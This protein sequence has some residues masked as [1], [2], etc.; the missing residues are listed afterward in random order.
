MR[1][2]Y[3][4]RENYSEY[5]WRGLGQ[6]FYE[7]GFGW[8]ARLKSQNIYQKDWDVL[9]LLDCTRRDMIQ[10]IKDEY[11]FINNIGEHLTPGTSSANW[12]LYTFTKEYENQMSET[13][14]VTG[15]PNSEKYLNSSDFHHLEE[16]WRNNWSEEHGTIL[17]RP[18]TNQAVRLYRN[19]NPNKMIVHYMQ[20]HPPFVPNKSVDSVEISVPN[21]SPSGKTVE[22]LAQSGYSRSE[23]WELHVNNLRYVLEDVEL[24]LSNIDAERA[25]ISADHGQALGERGK[26]GHPGA[27]TLDCLRKVPWVKTSASDSG[28]HKPV[29]QRNQ[30]LDKSVDTSTKEKLESLGYKT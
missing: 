17:P 23:L 5:G 13:L 14:H 9:V 27:S 4:L 10:E 3:S 12:M 29:K 28:Q 18:I 26:W 8:L 15:N 21:R 25:V 2:E 6:Y 20:P 11:D 1:L 22:E 19:M 30:D 7:M 24:L 16:V